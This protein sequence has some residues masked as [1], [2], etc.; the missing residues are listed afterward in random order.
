[1]MDEIA[2]DCTDGIR[3]AAYSVRKRSWI[4]LEHSPLP[5]TSVAV[6]LLSPS[7]LHQVFSSSLR[8]QMF[9]PAILFCLMLKDT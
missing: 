4:M 1:M 2:R 6:S 5:D 8:W 9:L 7:H 3:S